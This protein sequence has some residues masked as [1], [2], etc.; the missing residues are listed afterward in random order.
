MSKKTKKLTAVQ[1]RKLEKI[2]KT[3]SDQRRFEFH[4]STVLHE[5]AEIDEKDLPADMET[6]YLIV[7]E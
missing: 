3:Q 2:A 6:L 4:P 5:K 1:T 7:G